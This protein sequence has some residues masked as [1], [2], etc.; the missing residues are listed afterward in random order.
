MTAESPVEKP[1]S[2]FS[3]DLGRSVRWFT[4]WFLVGLAPFLG[5]AKVPGLAALIELYPPSLQSWLIPLSGIL[6]GMIAVIVEFAGSTRTPKRMVKRWFARTCGIF[7]ISFVL[8]VCVYVFTVVQI[9]RPVLRELNATPDVVNLAVITGS[10]VVPPQFPG[11]EC[12]CVARQ[13]AER[14]I[15]DISLKPANVAACFGSDRI[16]LATLALV[17]LYLAVTGSFVAGIGV[18][19]IHKRASA[20]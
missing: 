15:A 5:K 16:A 20:A 1:P 2:D 7:I 4:I 14:C 3:A 18:F 9:E 12:K 17:F 10:R 11:S 19:V 13:P 6:M 8:L